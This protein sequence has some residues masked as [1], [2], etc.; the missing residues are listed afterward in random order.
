MANRS[1][2]KKRQAFLDDIKAVE[3]KHGLR[4]GVQ[5]APPEMYIEEIPAE[6]LSQPKHEDRQTA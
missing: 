2:E 4:L 1:K 6:E 5:Q 3:R